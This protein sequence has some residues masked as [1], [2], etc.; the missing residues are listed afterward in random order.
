MNQKILLLISLFCLNCNKKSYVYTLDKHVSSNHINLRVYNHNK[1]VVL[2]DSIDIYSSNMFDT[3]QFVNF[4]HDRIKD[5]KILFGTDPVL[6]NG[7]YLY[8][9]DKDINEF[10]KIKGFEDIANPIYH[11]KQNLYSSLTLSSISFYRFYKIN[12]LYEIVQIDTT[13]SKDSMN[14]KLKQFLKKI[15]K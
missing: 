13:I 2:E 1:A 4:N 9:Y 10:K 3:V 14:F 11:K 15:S 8:L 7:Y 6:N 5:V 12:N